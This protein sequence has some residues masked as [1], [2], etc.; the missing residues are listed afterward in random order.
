MVHAD[1][2]QL[3]V[4][5]I[6]M[7]SLRVKAEPAETEFRFIGI[8]H[9]PIHTHFGLDNI[10]IGAVNR[11]ESGI[12]YHGRSRYRICTSCT[13]CGIC[14]SICKRRIT[15]LFINSI[16][17]SHT[18]RCVSVI[19]NFCFYVHF[20]A[21][22]GNIGSSNVNTVQIHVYGIRND[23]RNITIDT[24][25]GVPT[26]GRNG[27][28]SLYRDHIFGSAVTNQIFGNIKCEAGITIIMHTNLGTVDIN[29]CVHIN[30]VKIQ[31]NGFAFCIG[32]HREGFAIPAG[33]A[34]KE[35]GFRFTGGY[36]RLGN[37]EIVRKINIFPAAVI[38][39]FA[40]CGAGCTELEFPVLIEVIFSL[41][42]SSLIY[43]NG[44]FFAL[45]GF[46]SLGI[47]RKYREDAVA[48]Q[49]SCSYNR[50]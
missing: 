46:V 34:G 4:L 38:K 7:E 24:A 42:S 32:G 44:F 19:D 37:A 45:Y 22:A 31:K 1:T 11:P 12:G 8:H 18:D 21:S 9:F 25:A 43:F 27:V 41:R 23:Q 3:D 47:T 35:A 17:D 49:K 39:I 28:D 26:G 20:T 6:E 29:G 30:A 36:I 10:K 15:S 13:Y 48:D 5:S 16:G 14:G 2:V 50:C 33:S 40:M